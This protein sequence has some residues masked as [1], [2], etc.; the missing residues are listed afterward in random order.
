MV[1]H[2]HPPPRFNNKI[3]SRYIQIQKIN[4]KQNL[5]RLALTPK[6]HKG[7]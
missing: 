6:D 5:D 3:S 7:K 1:D 2:S 4:T